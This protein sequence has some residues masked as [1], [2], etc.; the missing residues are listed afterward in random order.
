MPSPSL[1]PNT[2]SAALC[3]PLCLLAE[4]RLPHI[5]LFVY[6]RFKHAMHMRERGGKGR[7]SQ[8]RREAQTSSTAYRRPSSKRDDCEPS[9]NSSLR[10]CVFRSFTN[11]LNRLTQDLYLHGRKKH[12][13]HSAVSDEQLVS[14]P[15]IETRFTEGTLIASSRDDSFHYIFRCSK[16]GQHSARA[17]TPSEHR[18]LLSH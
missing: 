6:T 1:H 3:T 10:K 18:T 13:I 8:R 11:F 2:K 17:N 14:L 9:L 12:L 4:P 16:N 5:L 7:R 15:S